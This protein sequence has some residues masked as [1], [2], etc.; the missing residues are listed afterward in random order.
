[1]PLPTVSPAGGF[2]SYFSRCTLPLIIYQHWPSNYAEFFARSPTLVYGMQHG[3]MTHNRQPVIDRN[4]SIVINTVLKT[5]LQ[6]FHSFLMQPFSV[7][8]VSSFASF[9]SRA[10]ANT[11]SSATAEGTHVRCFEKLL[12]C[13]F[14]HGWYPGLYRAAHTISRYYAPQLLKPAVPNAALHDHTLHIVI[15]KRP[16]LISRQIVNT[17]EL[18]EWCNNGGLKVSPTSPWK[19]VHCSEHSFGVDLLADIVAAQHADILVSH[20]GASQCNAFFAR[21]HSAWLELRP[22][23]FGT[24]HPFMPSMWGPLITHQLRFK[25]FW[26]GVN[27]EDPADYVESEFE[28]YFTKSEEGERFGNGQGLLVQSR[29]LRLQPE[30]LQFMVDQVVHV[31]K[32]AEAYCIKYNSN[33]VLFTYTGKGEAPKATVTLEGTKNASTDGCVHFRQKSDQT[34]QHHRHGGSSGR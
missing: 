21:A 27:I 10:P 14:N 5:P 22:Y 8:A 17:A 28:H 2:P 15:D 12:V 25:L 30:L 13:A 33:K 29:H 18:L 16:I 31:N 26:F 9:S 3:Q 20:H 11:S 1:M 19:K 24:K 34:V 23:E 7:H 6:K 32:T 4:I